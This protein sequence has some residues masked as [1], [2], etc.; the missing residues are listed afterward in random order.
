MR[1]LAVTNIFPTAKTPWL[2]TFVEQ[3][4]KGLRGSG[5]CVDVL[6]F[7]RKEQG[8]LI[9]YK[10]ARP[11]LVKV[12]EVVPDVV[13]VMYGGVMADQVATACRT[14]PV[15]VTFHGSDLL[16]ENLSGLVR[17]LIAR[18]GVYCSWRAAE[19][20][21]G[22]V[23]VSRGLEKALPRSIDR[24]KVHVI[25]CGIDLEM[26]RPMDK[27]QCQSEL[28]W[29]SDVTHVLFPSNGGDPVK[30]PWLAKAAVERVNALG[31]KTELHMLSGV[32]Y[33][34][35]PIW[36]NASDLLVLTS[37]HEGSPTVVKEALACGVGVVSVDVG[38]VSEQI[39]MIE[40]CHLAE[41]DPIDLADKLLQASSRGRRVNAEG[42]LKKLS[43]DAVAK[44]LKDCYTTVL[45]GQR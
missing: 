9:Y 24:R 5:L 29:A 19:R 27:A 8:P 7:D 2:G 22:V 45:R 34:L 41:S 10:M 33:K 40:G 25:P 31:R 18:Y 15:V 23:V 28:G 13:H 16:G 39:N 44:R 6:H 32:P 30:R 11:I 4:I 43:L 3:Q 21:T 38:D 12:A 37:L 17:K 1:I 42:V 26:F 36:I 14:K 35:V 20:A